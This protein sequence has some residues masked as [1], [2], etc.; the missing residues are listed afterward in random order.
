MAILE[1]NKFKGSWLNQ[2]FI[3]LRAC[4]GTW[5]IIFTSVRHAAGAVVSPEDEPFYDIMCFSLM[6]LWYNEASSCN[7]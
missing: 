2:A 1:Y 4:P 3:W 7:E 6:I 5:P